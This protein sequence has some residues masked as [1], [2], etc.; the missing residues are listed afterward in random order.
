MNPP[1][2]VAAAPPQR[3]FLSVAASISTRP[4]AWSLV[5]IL[6]TIA[7]A[8]FVACYVPPRL[9][10]DVLLPELSSVSLPYLESS[11][12]AGVNAS[13]AQRTHL[14]TQVWMV[15]CQP[16]AAPTPRP[17]IVHIHI[18]AGA[19]E[20]LELV[21]QTVLTDLID[22][23]ASPSGPQLSL[24]G[25][26]SRGNAFDAVSVVA[27]TSASQRAVRLIAVT[28]APADAA[29]PGEVW[30]PATRGWGAVVDYADAPI[31]QA[32]VARLVSAPSVISLPAAQPPELR[33]A[34][35][36]S[37]QLAGVA[38][39]SAVVA[40]GGVPSL[41]AVVH[42]TAASTI[43]HDAPPL[44]F[45]SSPVLGRVAVTLPRAAAVAVPAAVFALV[46]FFRGSLALLRS[47]TFWAVLLSSGSALLAAHLVLAGS[48]W[49]LDT[50]SEV[51]VAAITATG[52][53]LVV[54]NL[55]A[56]R[57]VPRHVSAPLFALV[58]APALC[59]L[60]LLQ[61]TVGAVAAIPWALGQAVSSLTGFLLHRT[62]GS[63]SVAISGALATPV[64]VSASVTCAAAVFLLRG[65]RVLAPLPGF[66]LLRL[67]G[68]AALSAPFIEAGMQFVPRAR[69]LVG[70]VLLLAAA[71]LVG[72]V[73]H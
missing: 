30:G 44:G 26:I 68:V 45:V 51:V 54:Q 1:P 65:S 42:A 10:L 47:R 12:P 35:L 18:P 64:A 34:Y 33:A 50:L 22:L 63:A 21:A 36:A 40:P 59:L 28:L 46:A 49:S 58:T 3:T 16:A 13:S 24:L 37:Q 67:C 66:S 20:G 8:F 60:S 32:L 19:P 4:E 31:E 5:S 9:S 27:G 15:T 69:T 43:R 53:G 71:L 48:L 23:N 14:G 2:R 11:C 73:E 52:T 72:R 39:A 57:N 61:P 62:Q 6:I 41:L 38:A 56:S 70:S 25:V 29:A 17:T 55:V 7:A